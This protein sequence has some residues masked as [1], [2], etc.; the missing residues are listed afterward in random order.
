MQWYGG[1]RIQREL[2]W[3]KWKWNEMKW[4]STSSYCCP[5]AL[6]FYLHLYRIN[7]GSSKISNCA[8]LQQF[9]PWWQISGGHLTLTFQQFCH[10]P[11]RFGHEFTHLCMSLQCWQ[12]LPSLMTWSCGPVPNLAQGIEDHIKYTWNFMLIDNLASWNQ[13]SIWISHVNYNGFCD[14]SSL[15]FFFEWDLISINISK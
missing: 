12:N 11:R 15:F 3:M 8:Y 4:L 10:E 2:T 9:F 1:F 6:T 14:F 5:L 13:D 7:T